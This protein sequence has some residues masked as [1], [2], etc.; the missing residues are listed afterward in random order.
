MRTLKMDGA[1]NCYG[2]K[3]AMEKRRKDGEERFEKA[4][5]KLGEQLKRDKPQ[6]GGS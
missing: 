3:A 4:M 1:Y 5:K 6:S 2:D